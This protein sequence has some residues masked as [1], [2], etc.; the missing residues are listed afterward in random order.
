[1]DQYGQANDSLL[2]KLYGIVNS[3]QNGVIDRST[4]EQEIHKMSSEPT[5]K[6][7]DIDIWAMVQ[8]ILAIRALKSLPN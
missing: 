1:M 8:K 5:L 6:N 7:S 2:S 3:W 4:F